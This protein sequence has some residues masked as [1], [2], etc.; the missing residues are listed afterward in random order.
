MGG[1]MKGKTGYIG[2]V[3]M[4]AMPGALMPASAAFLAPESYDAPFATPSRGDAALSSFIGIYANEKGFAGIAL[5]KTENN[6]LADFYAA[7]WNQPYWMGE[8]GPKPFVAALLSMLRHADLYALSPYDY[9]AALALK[10]D[11]WGSASPKVMAKTELVLMRTALLYARH[12][13]AGRIRPRSLAKGIYVDPQPYD[14]GKLLNLMASHENPAEYLKS[15]HPRGAEF[16][17][18]LEAYLD[19]RNIVA[20]GGWPVISKGKSLAIGSKGKRV[21]ELRK[22]LAMSGDLPG[23]QPLDNPVFDDVLEQALMS[24]QRRYGIKVDGVAGGKT[25]KM[26]NIPA[27]R[28]LEQLKVNLERRRWQPKDMGYRHVLV[29]QAGFK[30]HVVENKKE[31]YQSKVIVGKPRHATPEFSDN[32]KLVVLNPYWNVPRSIATKEILPILRRNPGYLSRKGM[33]LI[34]RNGRKVSPYGVNWSRVSRRSFNYRIRQRP[35]GGNALGRIK[36]MFPNKH[37]IYLHD[38]PSKSLFNKQARAFSHGCIR[39]QNPVKFAEVLMQPQFGWSQ[40]AIAGKISTRRNR[41]IKL[42]QKIP[43]HLT[44]RT[45]WAGDDGKLHFRDDIYGRDKRL[46]KALEKHNTLG[47]LANL[48]RMDD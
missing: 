3:L 24:A 39:V 30:L 2:A 16:K 9:G 5:S 1:S 45:V 26:L 37:S 31:I 11:E 7:R 34:N 41:A 44:Y 19:Y 21:I 38:T 20:R 42:K 46:A 8:N 40:K 29:N 17:R 32:I 18:L 47:K 43:V 28:R 12:A 48:R 13:G 14:P 15:L 23:D 35:S 27:S 4:L 33:S 6:A 22:R 36:F 10:G 25:R